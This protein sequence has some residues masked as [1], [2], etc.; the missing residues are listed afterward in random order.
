MRYAA[1]YAGNLVRLRG[2]IDELSVSHES[3]G[4]TFYKGN[5]TLPTGDDFEVIIN[6]RIINALGLKDGELCDVIGNIRNYSSI[7]G[8]KIPS[9]VFVTSVCRPSDSLEVN[10]VELIGT[11]SIVSRKNPVTEILVEVPR[12]MGMPGS[13]YDIV[14]CAAW[15]PVSEGLVVG[16]EIRIV[17]TLRARRFQKH[18]DDGNTE[19]RKMYEVHIKKW[20]EFKNVESDA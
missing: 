13:P 1:G 15:E 5:I 9:R 7:C 19:E 4:E 18:L 14:A 8:K 3:Y 20:E 6:G 16:K 17:G 2:T 12:V 11:I 10:T